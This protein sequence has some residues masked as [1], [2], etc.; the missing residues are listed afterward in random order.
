MT[1]AQIDKLIKSDLLIKLNKFR[2]KLKQQAMKL[3]ILVMLATISILE[4]IHV[5]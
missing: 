4:E 5:V 1:P 2:L 3:R